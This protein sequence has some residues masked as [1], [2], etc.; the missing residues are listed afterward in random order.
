M[1][2]R[3]LLCHDGT[4]VGRRALKQGA[5]LAISLGS[6]VHIL[7]LPPEENVSP[8][9]S[10]ASVEQRVRRCTRTSACKSP[11]D[12]QRRERPPAC[13]ASLKTPTCARPPH[14]TNAR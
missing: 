9:V 2:K 14:E 8:A 4:D 3:V 7:I 10:A 1:F 11:I 12:Y 13:C 6:D 5:E